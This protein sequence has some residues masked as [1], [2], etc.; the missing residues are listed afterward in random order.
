MKVYH[1]LQEP[2]AIPQ[3]LSIILTALTVIQ[4]FIAVML[5]LQVGFYVDN[6]LLLGVG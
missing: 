6:M 3:V 2:T 4:D 1:A 5:G